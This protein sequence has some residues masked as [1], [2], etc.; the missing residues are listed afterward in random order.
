M[1]TSHFPQDPNPQEPGSPQNPV[2]ETS[3]VQETAVEATPAAAVPQAIVP[4]FAAPEATN[5][6]P[7]A[8]EAVVPAS[9]APQLP[10]TPQAAPTAGARPAIE[11]RGLTKA[12]GQKVAVDRINLDIP[13]G[14]FYGLVGRNGAGKTTTISMV[15][16]MLMPSEGTAYVRGIDMW[17]D[18]LKAK[19]HLGV[20]PDGVHLFDKLTGEQLITYSGYLH[21]IDKETVASR[22]KD[23]LTAMDLTDAAGRAVADYSAGMTKKIALAAAL[24]HAPSVLIL[25][26]PFEAV[27]P[28]SAA[29]IQDILRGFVAS[30][31]TVIISSHVMDLVQRLC[32]HVAVMDSGR[33][34][35]A[36]TVDE[37]RAG[38]SLEERFVQLVGGRTSSEGLSWLGTSSH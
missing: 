21:G 1:N 24:V 37:V 12:F 30:G 23:L 28:V 27:D 10:V 3:P 19:A 18:P 25:D 29:N 6:E 20:L 13:S 11:I 33:I 7:V 16:G 31:G 15:T 22:V 4:E 35:A 32:D 2:Q 8:P 36:G 5:L 34:L 14:S 38:M 17:A 26:E 9:V